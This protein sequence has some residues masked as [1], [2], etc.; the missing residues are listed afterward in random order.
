LASIK[1]SE[2]IAVTWGTFGTYLKTLTLKVYILNEG[3]EG[4]AAY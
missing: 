3:G 1:P 2:S 4:K